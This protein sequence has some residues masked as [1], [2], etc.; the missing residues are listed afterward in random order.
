MPSLFMIDVQ[1][2][3]VQ[4]LQAFLKSKGDWKT[5]FSPMVKARYR[6]KN[7]EANA[8]SQAWSREAETDKQMKN[9][10]QNLSYRRELSSGETV[11]AGKWM[12][13]DGEDLEASLEE[14]FAKRLERQIGGQRPL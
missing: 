13:P 12:D 7:G 9:R 10:E 2:D 3:Q 6:G 11:I 1:S 4:P 8:D 14:W 5:T